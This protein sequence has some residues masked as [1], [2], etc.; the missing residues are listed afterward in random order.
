M[1]ELEVLLSDSSGIF[2]SMKWAL[3]ARVQPPGIH[4]ADSEHDICHS[5][6]TCE[7]TAFLSPLSA[8]AFSV[9]ERGWMEFGDRKFLLGLGGDSDVNVREFI[10][11]ALE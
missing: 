6:D 5:E 1:L 2:Y 7:Q 11:R 9:L 4:R 8:P 3:A 10:R